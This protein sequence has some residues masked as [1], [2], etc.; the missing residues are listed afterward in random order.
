MANFEQPKMTSPSEGE[1]AYTAEYRQLL[2][3][4]ENTAAEIE[5]AD[6][7]SPDVQFLNE[8]MDEMLERV[9]ELRKDPE[10]NYGNKPVPEGLEENEELIL[11]AEKDPA[12]RAKLTSMLSKVHKKSGSE[13]ENKAA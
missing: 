8:K 3:D 12:F 2:K 6:P 1:S 4:I 13:E 11:R 9:R 10:L 7:D 5:A